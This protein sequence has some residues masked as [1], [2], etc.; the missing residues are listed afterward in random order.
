MAF[1]ELDRSFA[2]VSKDKEAVLEH[3]IWGRK[4]GGWLDWNQLLQYRR[5]V[6]LAEASSG[7][8]EEFRNQQ[9]R[10]ATEGKPA[11]F[12]RIEELAD[13]GFEAALEPSSASTFEAWRAGTG[14]AHF[15]LDSVDEARLNRKG[16]ET[17]LKRF[18]RD[19]DRAVE[20]A[21][22]LISC[23]VTDWKGKEDF[24][25]VERILP[26]WEQPKEETENAD[27]LLDPIF[28]KQEDKTTRKEKALKPNELQVVQIVP[29]SDDQCR[30][31]VTAQDV[32]DVSSF[33]DGVTRSGLD[34]FTERPGD[35]LDLAEYWKTY[36]RFGNSSEMV[37]H[38]I[39]RKL[40]EID[41]YRA[42]AHVLTPAKARE[43]AE[44]LGAALT[45]GKSFTLRAPGH[46]ADPS[47]ASGAV[48]PSE[49]LNDWNDAERTAL[50]RRGIFAPSTYG[51]IRFHHRTTQEYLTAQ[52]FDRLLR[53]NCPREEVW[54]LVF[55]DRYGVET[56]VPSLRP[57]AAWLA[58]RQPEFREEII[59]RE[60]LVMIQ[61]GDPSSL[62]LDA[63]KKVLLSYA[64]KHAR[65]EIADDGLDHR[66]LWLFTEPQ[67]A[68]TIREALTIN[69]RSD[70]RLDILR[71]IR[72]RAIKAC[73]D[74]ART[75]V[76]NKSGNESGCVKTPSML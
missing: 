6:L 20:R 31:F 70:F 13:Q 56:L 8:T 24:A 43:G 40:E 45:F 66:S 5:V 2:P 15:F 12:V 16:F 53:S 65:A 57:A 64:R 47:L 9:A 32:S 44:R 37:E 34:A 71:M 49:V 30:T 55:A 59:R 1:V 19:L 29:L 50:L 61:H 51:R 11:F 54:S 52:W 27:P 4:Y 58:Q 33:M 48:D 3:G 74:I 42:D 75:E 41:A 60:P 76:T 17:A 35:I 22:I 26:S 25:L 7:K 14:I 68:D 10:L 21:H 62:S 46:D 28:N 39:A 63:K 73:V 69:A 23:R 18:A 38:G 72:D 67:L 36:G